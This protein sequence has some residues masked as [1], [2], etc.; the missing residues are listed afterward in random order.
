MQLVQIGVSLCIYTVQYF[1]MK[2]TPQDTPLHSEQSAMQSC[3]SA[4]EQS[5]DDY[6][7]SAHEPQSPNVQSLTLQQLHLFISMHTLNNGWVDQTRLEKIRLSKLSDGPSSSSQP[8]AVTRSLTI[9]SDLSWK[10]FLYGH[11]VK[12]LSH[13]PLNSIPN[14]LGPDSLQQ[15]VQFLDSCHLCPGNPDKHFLAMCDE[16]K[17]KFFSVRN[18]VTAYEDSCTVYLDGERYNRTIRTS[19][20]SIMVSSGRCS[21][22]T[23]FRPSLRSMYSRWKKK[24]QSP[25]NNRYLNTP[26]KTRKLAHLQARA[27]SA[28][29][30]VRLLTEK[31]KLSIEA[32]VISMVICA[33]L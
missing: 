16:R 26:Q 10:A 25:N 11:E 23:K 17:G 31:I 4:S 13:S 21:S 24:S 3:D 5:P 2:V 27:L 18:E 12:C 22:C 7:Q 20:C 33:Q 29:R 32:K 8:P 9:N 1:F 14:I 19:D 15:L 28:E 6:E 30:E